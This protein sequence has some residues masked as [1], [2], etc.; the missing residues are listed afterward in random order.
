MVHV[1]LIHRVS[2]EV[3]CGDIRIWGKWEGTH[4]YLTREQL[5]FGV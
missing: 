1:L 2:R 3:G 5:G 4:K